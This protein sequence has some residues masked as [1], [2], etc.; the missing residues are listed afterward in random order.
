M[1]DSVSAKMSKMSGAALPPVPAGEVH[2]AAASVVRA[3]RKGPPPGSHWANASGCGPA[4]VE[5][6]KEDSDEIVA[7][8]CGMGHVPA[9]SSRFLYFFAKTPQQMERAWMK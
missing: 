4:T 7:Y 1:P 6:E 9:K 8:G 3:V 2:A 5:N